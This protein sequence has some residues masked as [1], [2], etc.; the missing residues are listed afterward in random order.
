MEAPIRDWRTRP[1]LPAAEALRFPEFRISGAFCWQ[2]NWNYNLWSNF[3]AAAVDAELTRLAGLHFNTGL[4]SLPWGV[5]QPRVD[6]P[7]YDDDAY[8]RLDHLLDRLE[9]MRMYA[10]LRVG[11]AEHVPRGIAGGC[12]NAHSL[13]LDDSEIEAYAEFSGETARRLARSVIQLHP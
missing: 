2:G 9:A 3:T 4:V 8:G 5:F 12:Y 6:P 10:I 13:F 1:F 7:V 11:S